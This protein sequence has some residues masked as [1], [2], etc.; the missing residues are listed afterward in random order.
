MALSD[1]YYREPHAR[2]ECDRPKYMFAW[3]WD[4]CN[5]SH[6]VQA[7][8]EVA[9]ELLSGALLTDR[10]QSILQWFRQHQRGPLARS[11]RAGGLDGRTT[12][13]RQ[14]L[15]EKIRLQEALRVR[16]QSTF[17]NHNIRAG[18]RV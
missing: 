3:D 16:R 7:A 1:T 10:E 6:N 4:R 14:N 18:F 8:E 9:V 17:I 15:A 12:L 11:V 13:L 5:N 2:D